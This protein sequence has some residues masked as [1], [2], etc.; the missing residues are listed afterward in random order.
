[1]KHLLLALVATIP[2]L[3]HSAEE[4]SSLP[5]GLPEKLDPEVLREAGFETLFNGKDLT[6]WKSVG[7]NAEYEVTDDGIRGFGEDIKGNTFLRTEDEYG[8]F[9]FTFQFKFNYKG[10]NSGCMFRAF[11]KGDEPD[12]RVTGYQC[13]HDEFKDGRRAFTAGIYDEARR[14]WL[15]PSN[16][17]SEEMKAAFTEQGIR[18]F[19]WDGWNTIVIK[20]EGNRLQTWLNGEKR[21]DFTDTDEDAQTPE[22]FFGL[23]VHSGRKGD[24]VWRNLYLKEL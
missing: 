21:A 2:F 17:A 13:E 22:G 7:G 1:M 8:D 3:A 11:Q 12:G 5:A 23:Q 19:D 14:G 6:G 24:I 16:D 9:I 4:A 20:C 18:L 10:G 15:Y